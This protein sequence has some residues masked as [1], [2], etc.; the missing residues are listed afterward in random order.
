MLVSRWGGKFKQVLWQIRDKEMNEKLLQGVAVFHLIKQGVF[1]RTNYCCYTELHPSCPI[2]RLL[3]YI[4]QRF[5]RVCNK[6]VFVPDLFIFA[7]CADAPPQ[8]NK[9]RLAAQC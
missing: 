7:A 5:G 2:T 8:K 6:A 4:I 3:K 9:I 1:I